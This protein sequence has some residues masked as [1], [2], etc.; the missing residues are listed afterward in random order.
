MNGFRFV[1]PARLALALGAVTGVV[2][3]STAVGAASLGEGST[4]LAARTLEATHLPPLLTLEN[5]E[6]I[7]SYEAFC[8]SDAPGADDDCDVGGTVFV[9]SLE[10]G[11]TFSPVPLDP[12]SS[13]LGR[14]L[15][16]H[17]PEA[18]AG[19]EGGFEYYA[20]LRSSAGASL[21]VPSGGAAA[22]HRS[23]RL[24]T[25]VVIDLGTHVFGQTRRA[26]RRVAS[27]GWG[28]GPHDA[29]LEEGLN[30]SPIGASAFDVDRAGSIYVLDEAHRRVLR[31][32]DPAA[33]PVRIPVSVSG[34]LADMAVARDGSLYVLETVGRSAGEAPIVRHFDAGGRELERVETAERTASQIRMGPDGP[35]VLQQPSHHWMPISPEGA[36]VGSSTQRDQG[37]TARPLPGGGDVTVLRTGNEVRIALV[38][39]GGESRSWRVRSATPLGEVQLA[40]RFGSSFVLVTR[41]YTDTDA[42][43]DVLLLDHR[44]LVR[45]FSVTAAEWAEAAPLGRFRLVG[46]ALYRLGSTERG[47]F[48]D[49]FDL[50]ALR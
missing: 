7:L 20:E 1:P 44:G 29:G 32:D 25:P 27:A 18:L 5:E 49:R 45:R 41:A 35:V 3:G 10:G 13:A 4:R 21:T 40:E 23:M 39:P 6:V 37:R 17:V 34:S 22:P 16:A 43:F 26:D 36:M 31:W 11:A 15:V 42:E 2:A 14:Q 33:V 30:L 46:S 9:R 19:L 28:A 50:E 24:A 38:G 12:V 8:I 48:V 47:P